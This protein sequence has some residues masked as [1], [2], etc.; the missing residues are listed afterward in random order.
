M[1]NDI[2]IMVKSIY[3]DLHLA[4]VGLENQLLAFLK[5]AA[6]YSIFFFILLAKICLKEEVD[7]FTL[8]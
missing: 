5:V 4:I 8:D 2:L 3:F 6:L 1:K 7:A